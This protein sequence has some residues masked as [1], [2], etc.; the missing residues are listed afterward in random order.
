MSIAYRNAALASKLHIIV[1]LW[2]YMPITLEL[3][4]FFLKK[5]RTGR[6]GGVFEASV[7]VI[8]PF[9]LC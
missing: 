9:S 8:Q 4:I 2:T 7:D 1:F 5:N 6:M 3:V